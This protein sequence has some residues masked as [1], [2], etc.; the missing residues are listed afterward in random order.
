MKFLDTLQSKYV[1]L[2]LEQPQ[3]LKEYTAPVV[4]SPATPAAATPASLPVLNTV[5]TGTGHFKGVVS[6]LN[7]AMDLLADDPDIQKLRTDITKKIQ[8]AKKQITDTSTKTLDTV[9]KALANLQGSQ[10]NEPLSMKS[11]PVQPK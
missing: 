3:W 5:S 2:G 7:N 4:A 8:D 1:S 9:N 11:G 6:A 10:T